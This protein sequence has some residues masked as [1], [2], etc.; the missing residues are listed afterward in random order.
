MKCLNVIIIGFLLTYTTFI[1]AQQS[2][3]L[4]D[5][6]ELVLE[7]NIEK[8]VNETSLDY[9]KQ[10][11]TRS[12]AGL[13]PAVNF[14]YNYSNDNGSSTY[15][16]PSGNTTVSIE[17][18]SSE[19]TAGYGS[20][21]LSE[22]F[23]NIMLPFY[24]YKK[25]QQT[26]DLKEYEMQLFTEQLLL[27]AIATYYDVLRLEKNLELLQKT[28]DNATDHVNDIQSQYNLGAATLLELLSAKQALNQHKI[29]VYNEQ[30]FYNKQMIALATL[31]GTNPTEALVLKDTIV[32]DKSLNLDKILA[33]TKDQNLSLKIAN[34]NQL[35][36]QTDISMIKADVFPSLTLS[37][38]YYANQSESNSGYFR[39]I[40]QGGIEAQFAVSWTIFNRGQRF[41]AL[42]NIKNKRR[43]MQLQLNQAQQLVLSEAHSLFKEYQ[44]G[45]TVLSLLQ[46]A[47][48]TQ[49]KYFEQSQFL[50]KTGQSNITELQQSK[51]NL[52]T[53]QK[54]YNDK[55]LACR[56]IELRLYQ[57]SGNLLVSI[58]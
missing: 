50:F 43:L 12:E 26:V 15:G 6:I 27:N 29:N 24:T 38:G 40:E 34:Q 9:L 41:N 54:H 32:I 5:V 57:L 33:A 37:L 31:V 45:L 17:N 1:S 39:Q 18:D 4:T 20:M 51:I 19:S 23:T 21:T 11:S 36:S 47:I 2:L 55:L 7:N 46:D 42:K 35:L 8:Q 28:V 58:K 44:T 25:L 16:Y 14:S 3:T 49:K 48:T 52:L 30:L 53:A 13:Y 10:S 22:T 56:V